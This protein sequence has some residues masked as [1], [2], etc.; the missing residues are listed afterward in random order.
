MQLS[1]LDIFIIG[2]IIYIAY[3]GY[4]N[5]LLDNVIGFAGLLLVMFLAVQNMNRVNSLFYIYFQSNRVLSTIFSFLMLAGVG[6]FFVGKIVDKMQVTFNP[7]DKYVQADKILGGLLGIVQG[8]MLVSVV[9]IILTFMPAGG[10]L[11]KL[12]NESALLRPTMRMAPLV[13]NAFSI[14]LP[15]A[16]SFTEKLSEGF[17]PDLNQNPNAQD[18][19]DTMNGNEPNPYYRSQTPN[20]YQPN[21]DDY[22]AGP[23]RRR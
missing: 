19:L 11:E 12:R 6:W 22:Y 7:P 21:D 14:V 17:G 9:G 20:Q 23:Q 10:K 4:D 16:K 1:L 13:F 18:L 3:K 15:D 2:A 5:G 8:V